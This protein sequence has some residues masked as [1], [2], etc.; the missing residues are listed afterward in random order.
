[1]KRIAFRIKGGKVTIQPEGYSGPSCELATK[2][3]EEALGTLK[4]REHT[5]EFYQTQ[6]DQQRQEI[7]G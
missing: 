5:P 6:S 7:G 2:R 1:M 3:F 4:D